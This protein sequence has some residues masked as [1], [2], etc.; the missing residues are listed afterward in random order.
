MRSAT[1][2]S[3]CLSLA[4]VP[5]ISLAEETIDARAQFLRGVELF[6]GGDY[7][8]AAGAF[9]RS[10]EATPAPIALFNLAMCQRELFQY[11][12]SIDTLEQ[13]LARHGETLPPDQTA[14]AR[15]FIE[16]MA[17][18]IGTV[19]VTVEPADATVTVD[20]AEVPAAQLSSL[21][22][23]AGSHRIAARAPGHE[24]AAE[25]FQVVA[26]RVN[27]VRLVLAPIETPAAI[28]PVAPPPDLTGPPEPPQTPP[29]ERDIVPD[30]TPATERPPVHRRWGFWVGMIGAAVAVGLGVGLGVGLSQG[31]E[32]PEADV[33]TRLP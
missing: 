7:E 12:E 19:R 23:R 21:R 20:D 11:L 17:A 8:A 24:E 4:A 6:Q 30:D 9:R 13:Y 33:H 2:L 16:E 32:A 10:Y 15:R 29:E 31:D 27:E 3:L 28:E 5:R 22:L 25:T 26:Q 18:R 14:E 1:I